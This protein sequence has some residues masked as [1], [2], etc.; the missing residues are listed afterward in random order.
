MGLLQQA[1]VTSTGNSIN[2]GCLMDLLDWKVNGRGLC[3]E[4]WKT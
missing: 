4:L 2:T 1:L 3:E